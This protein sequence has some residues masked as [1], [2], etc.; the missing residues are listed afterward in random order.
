MAGIRPTGGAVAA[1]WAQR[2]DERGGKINYFDQ[3]VLG[4]PLPPLWLPFGPLWV[5]WRPFGRIGWM[6]GG[7][8]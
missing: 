6:S 3:A 5:Q 4:L 8:R 1:G 2:M 7:E